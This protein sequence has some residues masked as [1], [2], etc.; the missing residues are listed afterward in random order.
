MRL[1][2]HEQESKFFR[3]EKKEEE[4]SNHNDSPRSSYYKLISFIDRYFRVDLNKKKKRKM[5]QEVEYIR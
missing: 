2:T 4:E 3:F 5:M 1:Y